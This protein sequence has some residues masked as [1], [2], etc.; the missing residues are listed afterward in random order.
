MPS[1]LTSYP[2]RSTKLV[3]DVRLKR[4][5]G[6]CFSGDRQ[7]LVAFEDA[8][9]PP[10]QAACP[11]MPPAAARC[12]SLFNGPQAPGDTVLARTFEL[13]EWSRIGVIQQAQTRYG[14]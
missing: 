12:H 3:V 5:L 2:P 1:S 8:Q 7:C 9:K 14:T 10:S 13:E 11:A 6:W 4:V